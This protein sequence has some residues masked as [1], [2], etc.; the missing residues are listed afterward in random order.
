[1]AQ[2]KLAERACPFKAT[3]ARTNAAQG[4]SN[5]IQLIAAVY[6]IEDARS[7]IQLMSALRVRR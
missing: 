7:A 5:V 3:H 6:A 2:R 1:M 4:K